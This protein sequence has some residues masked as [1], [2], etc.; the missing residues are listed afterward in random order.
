MDPY[1]PYVAK[2]A[3]C[4]RHGAVIE[5]DLGE[6]PDKVRTKNDNFSIHKA[7]MNATPSVHS[8]T[9]T[10]Q[11]LVQSYPWVFGLLIAHLACA[12]V[13]KRFLAVF[14]WL[15]LQA[16][17]TDRSPSND[18]PSGVPCLNPPLTIHIPFSPTGA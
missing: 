18:D 4:R 17:S 14:Q 5:V 16:A 2:G 13:R 3:V 9:S 6:T 10:V 1:K 8:P 11:N 7:E 12:G 15:A